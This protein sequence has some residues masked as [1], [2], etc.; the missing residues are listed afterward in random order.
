[1]VLV[2]TV[3][4][5]VAVNGLTCAGRG[6]CLSMREA[7]QSADPRWSLQYEADYSLWDAD[8]IFGCACQEGYAGYDCSEM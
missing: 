6:K 3:S 8:M 7:A 4:C 1:M 5:P 2:A